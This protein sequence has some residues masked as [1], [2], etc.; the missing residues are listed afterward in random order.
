VHNSASEVVEFTV[1]DNAYGAKLQTIAV[2]ASETAKLFWPVKESGNWYDFSVT[3]PN[4]FL[5]KFVGRMEDG[6][7][8]ITDPMMCRPVAPYDEPVLEAQPALV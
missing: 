2:A 3:G 8:H 4:A 1:T 5:R 6:K 7:D